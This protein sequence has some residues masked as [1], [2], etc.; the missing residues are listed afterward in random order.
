MR[1][2]IIITLSKLLWFLVRTTNSKNINLGKYGATNSQSMG[3]KGGG[4][5]EREGEGGRERE[6]ERLTCLIE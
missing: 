5:R 6:R 1:Y 2:W 3:R 4:E